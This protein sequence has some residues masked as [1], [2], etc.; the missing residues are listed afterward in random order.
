MGAWTVVKA[1]EPKLG[2]RQGKT[3]TGKQVVSDDLV[4]VVS[5]EW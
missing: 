3:T 1:Q 2:E 4:R 5:G